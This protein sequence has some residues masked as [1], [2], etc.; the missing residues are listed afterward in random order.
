MSVVE[1][2]GILAIASFII[3]YIGDPKTV[4]KKCNFWNYLAQNL[5]RFLRRGPHQLSVYDRCHF[6][7][8]AGARL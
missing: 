7:Q 6:T 2:F 3:H 5:A 8:R 1:R 4:G